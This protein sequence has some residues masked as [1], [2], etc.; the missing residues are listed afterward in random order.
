MASKT[1][2][3]EAVVERLPMKGSMH[4]INVPKSVYS[5]F[6]ERKAVRIFCTINDSIRYACALRPNGDGGFFINVATPILR[7]AKIKVG[8]KIKVTIKK[9]DTEYG[10]T[11]PEELTELLAQDKEGK[12]YWDQV[13]NSAQRAMIYYIAQA[14]SIDKRIER[15]LLF[16]N[17]LKDKAGFKNERKTS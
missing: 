6:S 17:R 13:P 15:S 9:D 7:K 10:H 12:K 1:I 16:I 3:F 4:L 11:V 5:K 8:Q 14:K 2:D